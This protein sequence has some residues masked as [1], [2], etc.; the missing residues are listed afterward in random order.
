MG[1]SPMETGTTTLLSNAGEG[2]NGAS[3]PAMPGLQFQ[4]ATLQ[5][6]TSLQRYKSADDLGKAY[7]SLEQKMGQRPVEV[8]GTESPPEAWQAFWKQLPDYP[9]SDEQYTANVPQL[10]QG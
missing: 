3:A 5:Q 4:D 8:P 2:S 6:S 9:A 1:G 10:P 7:L